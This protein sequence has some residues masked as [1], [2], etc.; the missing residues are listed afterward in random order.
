MNEEKCSESSLQFLKIWRFSSANFSRKQ[1]S[2][3]T[4]CGTI[5][6]KLYRQESTIEKEQNTN[7]TQV[8]QACISKTN[9][10]FFY[11]MG[12]VLHRAYFCRSDRG[13]LH[14]FLNPRLNEKPGDVHLYCTL[15]AYRDRNSFVPTE[16]KDG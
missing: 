6:S 13:L 15:M 11:G 3:Q 9:L 16:T 7:H 1:F 10:I 14:H 8:S 5:S 4:I 12:K 2:K